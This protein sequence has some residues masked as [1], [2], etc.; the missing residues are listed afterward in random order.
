[1]V[2]KNENVSQLLSPS[3]PHPLDNINSTNKVAEY[4]KTEQQ[5]TALLLS[6]EASTISCYDQCPILAH[7][8]INKQ[9]KK[10]LMNEMCKSKIKR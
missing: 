8:I 5:A 10:L 2:K 3:F 6:V 4:T 7:N 9:P 1:M